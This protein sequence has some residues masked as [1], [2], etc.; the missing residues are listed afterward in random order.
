MNTFGQAFRISI[1][2]ASHGPAIGVQ[3]DGCPAGLR[4][5]IEKFKADMARRKGGGRGSTPRK[6]EDLPSIL[7]G[8][9]R[10][11]TTGAPIVMTFNNEET[12][13]TW[14]EENRHLPRPG[15]ADF[16]AEKK[17]GGYQDVRGGGASSGRLTTGLVAAGVIAKL[18]LKPLDIEAKVTR[19]GGSKDI[20]S[21]IEKALADND[22][23]GGIVEC[24]TSRLPLGLGEPFFD[25]VESLLA[26]MMFSIGAVKGIE[27]GSGF[28]LADM[29]GSDSNDIILDASGK[30]GSNHA[31]GLN[32]GMSNGN[33][34][35]FR[36]V[37]KPTSSIGLPQDTIDINTGQPAT[38]AV[39]GRHDACIALRMPVIVEAGCAIVLT[40][41]M[42]H[43]Q[44]IPR[45]I[46]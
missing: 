12:Q 14:Y 40:D 20:E 13:S 26:H 7:S 3:V 1:F 35:I 15:H 17:Y 33:E 25:S 29:A 32:G 43:E 36:V 22:S 45:R 4:L 23:V 42:L 37:I 16:A 28:A 19:V 31:G 6:E 38:L 10:G 18:L 30:T 9:Y 41:L 27:F 44:L 39:K 46:S 8:L 2:G 24:R 11:S 34:M 5:D 21:R